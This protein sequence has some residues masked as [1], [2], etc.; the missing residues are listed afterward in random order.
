MDLSE[1]LDA[2]PMSM[3]HWKLFLLAGFGWAFDM[4]AFSAVGIVIKETSGMYGLPGSQAGLYSTLIYLGMFCGAESWSRVCDRAG[5]RVAFCGTIFTLGIFLLVTS[6]CSSFPALFLGL[7]GMGV[8]AGGGLVCRGTLLIEWAPLEQRGFLVG[9]L[10]VFWPVGGSAAAALSYL[11]SSIPALEQ[12]WCNGPE[13]SWRIFLAGMGVLTLLFA[14]LSYLAVPE[15][16]RWLL[17]QGQ[18]ERSQALFAEASQSPTFGA[19]R[20]GRAQG[21]KGGTTPGGS[22]MNEPLL[23]SAQPADG[24]RGA[25]LLVGEAEGGGKGEQKAGGA[26]GA[27]EEGAGGGEKGAE[28][29][30]DTATCAD[31]FHPTMF[32]T[33]ALLWVVWFTFSFGGA[34]VYTLLPKILENAGADDNQNS[35]IYLIANLGGIP[36]AILSSKLLDSSW[37]RKKTLIATTWA[38][39]LAMLLMALCK[40]LWLVAVAVFLLQAVSMAGWA[41][42]FAY[43][44]EVYP[45]TIRAR[46]LGAANML[47]RIGGCIGP[48]VG[49]MLV[50]YDHTL[51]LMTFSA[52]IAVGAAATLFLQ[53]ET[54]GVRLAESL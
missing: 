44:P 5:R 18:S 43:T 40:E 53:H 26:G 8:G 45:T 11:T 1:R 19:W 10:G 54:K 9:A 32:R 25:A 35:L 17:L 14:L 30:P 2:L 39:A 33:T 13:C 42:I 7:F 24:E 27:G 23:D 46:G 48:Y 28:A 29:D 51:A 52:A 16:A 49:G 15:S 12:P 4:T 50:A 37:G 36:G 47:D 41:V 38:T 3:F 21:G 22:S 6:V 34:A 20:K 31:L